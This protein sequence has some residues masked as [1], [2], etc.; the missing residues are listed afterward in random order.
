MKLKLMN[1]E[2]SVRWSLSDHCFMYDILDRI[3]TFRCHAL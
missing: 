2:C 3:L 1:Q